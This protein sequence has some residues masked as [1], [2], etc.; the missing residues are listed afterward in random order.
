MLTPYPK[1]LLNPKDFCPGSCSKKT[2]VL[3][4][5]PDFWARVQ[6]RLLGSCLI[7]I[8]G[9]VFKKDFRARVWN[10]FSGSCLK[11][12]FGLVF[13]TDF[14]ARVWNRFSFEF[15]LRIQP[16]LAAKVGSRSATLAI[17]FQQKRE[18]GGTQNKSAQ[19]S[20]P[21]LIW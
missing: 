13:E 11:P 17:G 5:E 4:V 1:N 9:L 16:R 15:Q 3:L 7:P 18:L 14:R 10:R 8:F 19:K 2:F 6:K 21:I 20:D 12:I